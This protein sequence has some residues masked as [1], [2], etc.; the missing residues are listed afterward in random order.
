MDLPSLFVAAFPAN[1]L[2]MLNFAFNDNI[3]KIF[4]FVATLQNRISAAVFLFENVDICDF[5]PTIEQ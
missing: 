1:L 5:P 3:F 2:T 4:K